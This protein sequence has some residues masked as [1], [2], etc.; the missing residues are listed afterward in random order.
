MYLTNKE[1]NE[2]SGG[3]ITATFLNA[4]SRLM[5]TVYNI[6]YAV[7]STIRRISSGKM[8]RL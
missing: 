8:C 6:G 5:S 2:V 3:G 1:L 4:I 7:G